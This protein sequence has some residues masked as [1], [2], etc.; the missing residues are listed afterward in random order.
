MM[1]R[2]L[3]LHPRQRLWEV[4]SEALPGYSVA[5]LKDATLVKDRCTWMNL[6]NSAKV[7]TLQ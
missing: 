4:L 5:C 7:L 6:G 3:T 1:Y 2:H